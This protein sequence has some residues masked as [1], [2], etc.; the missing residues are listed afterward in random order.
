MT[1]P[2]T[3]RP[4]IDRVY[5][6]LRRAAG[7]ASR[8]I[9]IRHGIAPESMGLLGDVYFAALARPI[10][11]AGIVAVTRY[12]DPAGVEA[13]IAASVA[14]G[15]V[16]RDPSGTIILTRAGRDL[17]FEIQDTVGAA[18]EALWPR[19]TR[20]LE[21]LTD[22]LGRLIVT[23]A[24]TGGAAFA[25]MAP[26]YERA[27]AG[28]GVRFAGRLGAFRHHRADAHAAAWAAAGLTA[29]QMVALDDPML[30]D[31][32]EDDTNRRDAPVYRFLDAYDRDGFLAALDSL[33]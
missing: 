26:P 19:S 17:L 33:D 21:R 7:P 1:F 29:T 9:V 27:A 5:S 18:T 13:S 28:R 10:T 31:Q 4:R 23:G 12:H 22:V 20:T 2:A 30:R 32:I 6:T 16:D 14:D 24:T 25:A 3:I 15:L 8:E 11:T